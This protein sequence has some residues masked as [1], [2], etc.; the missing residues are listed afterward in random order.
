MMRPTEDVSVYLCRES[1]DMRKSINGLSILVEEGLGLDPF[2]EALYV[3]AN[4][5]RCSILSPS[6]MKR[7][8]G[9]SQTG[10]PESGGMPRDRWTRR[11][12]RTTRG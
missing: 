8:V 2:G 10:S 12:R 7:L 5:K 3:F 9:S 4:R 11:S 1:V 6:R